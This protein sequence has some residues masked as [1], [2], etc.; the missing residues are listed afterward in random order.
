MTLDV[1]RRTDEAACAQPACEAESSPDAIERSSAALPGDGT[2]RL[3][4]EAAPAGDAAVCVPDTY[5]G[6]VSPL[7]DLP[8]ML[9]QAC[10]E[11]R[12]LLRV[13]VAFVYLVEEDGR[14]A[15]WRYDSGLAPE[16]QA[17]V[18]EL[19]VPIGTGIMGKAIQSGELLVTDD[20]VHDARFFDS[21]YREG[22][23]KS[24]V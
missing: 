24:V 20:W 1:E 6:P 8:A 21:V 3:D 16:L 23:R 11:A 10:D 15:R 2:P 13:D 22:D 9:K 18:R 7:I 17:G 14:L 5:C 12:R 19:A 4:G